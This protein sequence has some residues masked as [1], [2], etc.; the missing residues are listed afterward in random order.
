MIFKLRGSLRDVYQ[1]LSQQSAPTLIGLSAI[2]IADECD[3]S[4]QTVYR[5]IRRLKALQLIQVVKAS[6]GVEDSYIVINQRK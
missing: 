5:S 1:F 4:R 3:V 2:K 6:N